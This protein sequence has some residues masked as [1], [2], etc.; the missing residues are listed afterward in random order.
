MYKFNDFEDSESSCDDFGLSFNHPII[1][2]TPND[3]YCSTAD[4]NHD[5]LNQL[6]ESSN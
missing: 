2:P 3:W 6:F 4:N 5:C 1:Q